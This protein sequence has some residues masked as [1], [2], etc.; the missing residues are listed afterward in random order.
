MSAGRRP[1]PPAGARGLSR[2][3]Q[4]GRARYSRPA[5]GPLSAILAR[6]DVPDPPAGRG[7]SRE[8]WPR[9]VV[10]GD[11]NAA[12]WSRTDRLPVH[13]GTKVALQAEPLAPAVRLL[14]RRPHGPAG[15]RTRR[16]GGWR[17]SR[18]G[19]EQAGSVR[20]GAASDARA[21]SRRVPERARGS[22]RP[23]SG[24]RPPVR[25]TWGPRRALGAAGAESTATVRDRRLP[26][27]GAGPRRPSVL[28]YRWPEA[29]KA[30]RRGLSRA[31]ESDR[32][33]D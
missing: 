14:L 28:A 29:A 22:H 23:A 18:V 9:A 17:R 24:P 33:G 25:R 2:E 7:R 1:A 3:L 6:R 15:S 4:H 10:L 11:G 20:I 31:P 30:A 13:H 32:A 8:L 21:G 19:L 12:L 27:T 16:R 5:A 26:G